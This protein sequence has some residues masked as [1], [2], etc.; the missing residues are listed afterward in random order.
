MS[1]QPWASSWGVSVPPSAVSSNTSTGSVLI[2]IFQALI[3]YFIAYGAIQT[4]TTAGFRIPWAV[5]VVP[6]ILL[7]FVLF[8]FPQS[9][10]WLASQDRMDECVNVLAILHGRGDTQSPLVQAEFLEVRENMEL[11]R[12]MGEVRWA[13]LVHRDNVQRIMAGV[14]IHIWTQLSGNNAILF[15]VSYIFEMTGLS[16]NIGLIAAGVQYAI[17]VIFTLPAILFLDKIGRRPALMVGS[18]LMMSFLY[19][20]AIIMATNGHYVPGGL[21]GIKTISWVI[22]SGATNAQHGVIACT[23]MLAAAYCST[24]NPIG[25]VYPPEIFPQ[26]LRGK[27]VSVATSA[28]W[29]FGFANSYYTPSA[30]ANL[31]W[32]TFLIFGSFNV[33]AGIQTFFFF[34]ETKGRSLEGKFALDP[35]TVAGVGTKS[36]SK[37]WTMSSPLVQGPGKQGRLLTGFRSWWSTP[38]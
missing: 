12:A 4:G 16:G 25:W 6:A 19:A 26:R 1:L 13:E 14:F 35:Q 32:K 36:V 24:W 21:N 7:F 20:T 3:M 30:F 17:N 28:N 37:I 9:P 31:Q 23:Y 15:Y 18:A 22:N 5:Q 27:A 10:R 34:P 2:C 33:V 38:A 8:F 11:S 29:I